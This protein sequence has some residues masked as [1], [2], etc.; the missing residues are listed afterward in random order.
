MLG[1]NA[2]EPPAR[3]VRLVLT[4]ADGE[5]VGSLAPFPVETPWWQDI[6]P[7]VRGARQ[8]H[9]V[10]VTVLRLLEA[11]RQSPH[12]GEVTYLAEVDEPV[13]VEPWRGELADHPLRFSW[14]RAGGPAEDLAWADRA[15][16]AH[17]LVRS[18][19]EQIRTWHLS[20]LWR[21]EA[22]GRVVW[23]KVVPWFFA[24]EGALLERLSG[25][26]VPPLLAR[27]GGRTL[28]AEL[29]G[30]D[31]YD[32][33]EPLL[34]RMVTLAVE[35]QASWLDRGGELLELDL[36][37]YRAAR[38]AD[39]I[40]RLI[41]RYRGELAPA[42]HS[43][44]ARFVEALP[45]R[46]AALDECGLP[47]TLVHGD[48]H[49]GNFRGGDAALALLDWSDSGVGHPLLDQSAFLSRIPA[50]CVAALRAHWNACWR[51][52]VPASDPERAAR[53]LAPVAAARQA[54]L[55]RH[56]LDHIEPA[57]QP[58]HRA[59]PPAWL[60]RTAELARLPV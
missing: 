35:L 4:R 53:L 58:Y 50:E 19:A 18:A 15:L 40:P 25:Q 26:P 32:A 51:R 59:D 42:D 5:L 7:V 44:L 20:S 33:P 36:L 37:D 11:Q 34:R 28:L 43:T 17:G 23:L 56:F 31:L 2:M 47:E 55:Y 57:E 12:G 38:L 60:A 9:G 14:A 48:L 30:E 8:H 3:Y 16:A 46:L 39:A 41:Q 24:H 6:A 1:R 29:P 13:A 10:C 52:H 27:D 45:A 22:S 54:L 21:L 49:P